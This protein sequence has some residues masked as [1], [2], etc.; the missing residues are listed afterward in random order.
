MEGLKEI[1]IAGI[2]VIGTIAG[3]EYWD[4]RK[5]KTNVEGSQ[6]ERKIEYLKKKVDELET[7]L[8]KCEDECEKDRQIKQER[9]DQLEKANYQMLYDI[10]TMMSFLNIVKDEE[11][12]EK[13]LKL[14]GKNYES[15]ITPSRT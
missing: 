14:F 15:E 7:K 2:S 9:I 13:L 10:K 4:Y 1:I 3:K 11:E 6:S 5:N 12:R 8:A